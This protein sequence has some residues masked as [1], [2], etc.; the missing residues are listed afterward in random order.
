MTPGT[1]VTA[2]VLLLG[3][4]PITTD[5]YLPA[6]PNLQQ[7]L[8][9]SVAATQLTLSALIIGFGLAQLVCGPLADRFG[10]RPVLLA[11]LAFY[12]VASLLAALAPS[13]EWLV[14]WR[15]LQGVAMAAAVTCGRSIVR[16]LYRP[17]QGARVLARGL[18][19]LGLLAFAAPLLGGAIVHVLDWHATLLVPALFGGGSLAFIALRFEE[20]IPNR[21]PHATRL[22]PLLRNWSMIVAHPTFRAYAA[23]LC[24]TYA[25]LFTLLAASSF[26]YIGVLGVSRLACGAILA[27]NSL[28]YVIGTV[29]CRRLLKHHGLRPTVAIG[30]A[31]SLSGGLLTALLSLAGAHEVSVWSIIVPSWL[32]MVGHGMHQP[33]AQAGAIGPFPDK[34]GTAASVSGFLMMLVA[35]G[36]GLL[37]GRYLN[38]T[39]FPMTLGLG[40]FGIGVA[41]VAWTSVQ[42][43][44]EPAQPALVQPL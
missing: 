4:Q 21:N 24:L 37:L 36:V 17:Q 6:L 9:A 30:G 25:G 40:G 29:L 41:C 14:V 2:L 15:A 1:V 32:F 43:H 35:F 18:G 22:V 23:L 19:G 3:I 28:F 10:R 12:S 31:F 33:C 8:G 7:D 39:V 42:R 5:L 44:G 16:D 20:T 38:G 11:G 34:A 27:V 13:I 26:V